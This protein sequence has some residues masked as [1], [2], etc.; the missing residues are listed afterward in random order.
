MKPA[1][2]DF[3]RIDIE[4]GAATL[5]HRTS[6]RLQGYRLSPDGK[7]FYYTEVDE[8]KGEGTRLMRFDLDS[9]QAT[10]LKGNETYIALAVSPDNKQIAY[11]VSV[12]PGSESYIAVM[13]ASGGPSRE[14]Y[15][16]TPW[17]DGSRYN[18]LG[19]TAD[20]KYVM[21][22]RG[23]A[24]DNAPNVLWRVPVQGGQA[25]QMGLSLPA[26]IRLPQIDPS[27]QH[28]YFSANANGPNELWAL[29]HF[30]K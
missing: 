12:R 17:S 8:V 28:L 11:L 23:A 7:S 27:G 6:D 13:P 18:T 10:E 30:L 9:K 19:W 5:I 14:I 2:N 3:Y 1:A 22:V 24:G 21:F 16:G 4:S 25:E 29:E 26:S 15:R 20:Q